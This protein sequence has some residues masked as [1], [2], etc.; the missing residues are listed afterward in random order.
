MT[1][2]PRELISDSVDLISLPD[3][4]IQVNQMIDDPRASAAD[5]GQVIASDPALTTR[6]LKIVNSAF[7]SF[8]S[9]IDTVS[10][11]ITVV[12]V[13]D[14]RSLVLA[15]SAVET[16]SR[17]PQDLVDM[18]DFWV[19]SIQ[20]AIIARL[21][22]KS[23]R[24]LQP[25]RLFVAGLLSDIGC[26]LMYSKQPDACREILQAAGD[27]RV[28]VPDLEQEILGFTH[29]DAGGEL[30]RHWGLPQA[31]CESVGCHLNPSAA[32][33]F[34]LDAHLVYMASR[35][36]EVSVDG[37]AVDELLVEIDDAVLQFLEMDSEKLNNTL[38]QVGADFSA[39]FDLIVPKSGVIY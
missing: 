30:C 29:A 37:R 24:V 25:E 11:A 6:L 22:A 16:F 35:L 13:Q 4:A 19:R 23:C 38:K 1:M 3:V 18:T 7:Y 32:S 9:K 36:C 14:L 33:E 34:C 26:L 2:T 21:L 8:P 27:N 10:R 39:V 31:L 15:T 20:C 17:I 12:G 5:M 28:I